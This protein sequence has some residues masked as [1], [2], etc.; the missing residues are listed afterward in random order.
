MTW[1]RVRIRRNAAV[2]TALAVLLVGLATIEV[3]ARQFN[4]DPGR[5]RVT[6]TAAA[7]RI[8]LGPGND[9]ARAGA[10]DDLARGGSGRDR[11]IGG[12]G[13]DRLFGQSGNDRLDGETGDD[14]LYGDSGRDNLYGHAGRDLLRGGTADDRVFGHAGRD[15]L[16]GDAGSDWLSGGDDGDSLNG[17]EGA[18]RVMGSAGD[19]FLEGRDAAR[20][21]RVHGGPGRDRCRVD[22]ADLAI[23]ASCEVIEAGAP[24]PPPPGRGGGGSGGGAQFVAFT[25]SSA[26]GTECTQGTT[27]EM[28]LTGKGAKNGSVAV[29]P[30][31]RIVGQFSADVKADGTW[32]V[33]GEYG[34]FENSQVTLRSGDEQIIVSVTCKQA[35]PPSGGPGQ[36]PLTIT[37]TGNTTCDAPNPQCAPFTISGTG[38]D[39]GV[40]ARIGP[41]AG[42]PVV[43]DQADDQGNWTLTSPWGCAD[44]GA[45]TVTIQDAAG[46]EIATQLTCT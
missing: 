17:G 10:G 32:A 9:H 41:P 43:A 35:G 15:N 21:I 16:R 29:E 46:D 5:D 6:G 2:G 3:G 36:G 1:R 45:A 19:D 40:I 37:A 12:P 42:P 38:G 18:D 22:T 23:V 44:A 30:G 27:C 4:G 11:L 14:R 26:T 39:Q 8:F 7:D 20:D 24:P 28:T 34:C 31:D 13:N 25:L 33:T